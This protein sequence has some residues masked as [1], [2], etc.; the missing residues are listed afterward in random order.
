MEGEL[1]LTEAVALTLPTDAVTS[2]VPGPWPTRRPSP[3]TV[4]ISGSLVDHSTWTLIVLPSASSVV[5]LSW[6][7]WPAAASTTASLSR[8]MSATSDGSV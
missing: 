4:T 5:A 8:V 6:R 3:S 7:V 2:A 1:T